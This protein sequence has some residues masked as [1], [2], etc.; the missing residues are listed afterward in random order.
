MGVGPIKARHSPMA[1]DKKHPVGDTVLEAQ[2][3]HVYGDRGNAWHA[4]PSHHMSVMTL[5][6]ACVAAGSSCV[7]ND[8]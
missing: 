7:Q 1:L 3:T 6:R 2:H 8:A 4:M 5:V